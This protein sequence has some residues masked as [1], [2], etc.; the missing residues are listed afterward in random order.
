[1]DQGS[2]MQKPYKVSYAHNFGAYTGYYKTYDKARE[3]YIR[4]IAH[5]DS[6]AYFENGLQKAFEA[7]IVL[8]N[9]EIEKTYFEIT[10]KNDFV[11]I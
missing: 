11:V 1:M 10:I 7:L 5:C 6:L 2:Q 3:A 8:K 4:F 9:V